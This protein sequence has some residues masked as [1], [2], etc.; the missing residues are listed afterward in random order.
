[1]YLSTNSLSYNL[2]CVLEC[3]HALREVID[4]LILRLKTF[5]H[6]VFELLSESSELSHS[7][8]LELFNILMLSLELVR[9]LVLEHTELQGLIST[10]LINL[11]V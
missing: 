8:S 3:F 1:M 11:L 4:D 9:A 2:H 6:L 10:L 5:I 7:F